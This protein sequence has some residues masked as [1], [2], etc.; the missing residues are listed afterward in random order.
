MQALLHLQETPVYVY[1]H[2]YV[3]RLEADAVFSI[4]KK[5]VHSR[6]QTDTPKDCCVVCAFIVSVSLS[7]KP[8]LFKVH[9]TV[10]RH[11]IHSLPGRNT[12]SSSDT[13]S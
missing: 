7:R 3:L 8:C 11:N 5:G 12:H 10:Q 4:F 1:N 6:A 9:F 2:G 13:V